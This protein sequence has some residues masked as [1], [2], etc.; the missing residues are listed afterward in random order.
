MLKKPL[1][2]LVIALV[3]ALA[4]IVSGLVMFTATAT[5]GAE[6][7]AYDARQLR[8]L[9]QPQQLPDSSKVEL[10][11][12]LFHDTR[13]SRDNTVSCASC[14][15]LNAGG[16]DGL[17]QAVGIDEQ[18]GTVNTPTVFNSSLNFVQFWD[19]RAATL[20][21]QAAGPVHNP[22]EMDS[23][24]DSVIQKLSRDDAY[25]SAFQ[26]IYGDA[27]R[28][29]HIVDAIAEFERSLLTPG[30]RFDRFLGGDA[31]ALNDIEKRGYRLFVRY[32]C[33][34]C[35]QGVA[36]G[37]NMYQ[38]FGVVEGYFE[39]RELKQSDL[40]RYNVTGRE[41]DRYVFKVPGLR[42]V[43]KTAPYFHDGRVATLDAAVLIMGRYQLGRQLTDD[44]VSALVAFL[45][46]LSAPLPGEADR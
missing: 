8:P 31:T 4:G 14:H 11:H 33:S 35:H 13:L 15:R 30:S 24:W 42:N 32:G 20:E 21:E 41:E 3:F 29:E 45:H 28:A 40:G 7:S 34:S 6:P 2:S 39:G 38:R 18:V 27:I 9:Q 37:G 36:L 46:T 10:G 17:P 44:E 5:A 23:D 1:S 43:A 26:R 12:R 25:V 22:L 16:M 19:G